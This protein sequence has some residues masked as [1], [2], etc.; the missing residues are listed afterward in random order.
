M[1][2]PESE[3]GERRLGAVMFTDV[4][5]YSSLTSADEARALRLLEDHRTALRPVIG[6][7]HGTEVKT[8]G[9]AF[10][11][12][13]AS[14]VEAVNCAVEM[15]EAMVRLN[16]TR[17]PTDRLQ[18]RVGIHV[19]D[20]VH[21]KGDV[22]GDAVNVA[23]RVEPLAEPGGICITRQ[24]VD[25]VERKVNLKLVKLGTRDL[26]NISHPIEVYKVESGLGDEASGGPSLDPRRIAILPFANLSADPN[27]RYFADGMTEELISTVSSISELSVISRTSIMRYKDTIV[28]IGEIGRELSAG[29]VLEGSIRKAGNRVRVTTQLIDARSD[30]HLWA[31]SYD[32]DVTDIFAIQGDI[33]GQV[34]EALRVKLVS[35]EKAVIEKKATISTEAHTLYLKGRYSWNDRTR[36][37]GL[38]AIAYYQEAVKID[39]TF[40]LAYCGLSDCYAI[41][42]DRGWISHQETREKS[43]GYA[44]KALDL[45]PGLA[46]AHASMGL[47]LHQRWDLTGAEAELKRSIEL[48]PNFATAYHWYW[49]VLNDLGR[50][51]EAYEAEKRALELD[52]YSSIVRQGI[53]V[54]LM[55]LKRY[56][57]ALSHLD[58]L[59]E[60]DPRFVSVYF[61]AAWT[62]YMKGD[63]AGAIDTMSKGL[64]RS[65]EGSPGMEI[66]LAWLHT[67]SGQY[68]LAQKELDQAITRRGEG[69]QYVSPAMVAMV[70][71]GLGKKDEGFQYLDRALE[72]HDGGLSYFRTFPWL[73]EYRDDPRWAEIDRKMGLKV[74]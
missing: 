19:G 42:E 30:R 52:P 21:S 28:P 43:L 55:Y 53:G 4:V 68:E 49:G 11:V 59:A 13:F 18:I 6:R 29:T 46:E 69:G 25:N 57:E 24:V 44:Q 20:I 32:R 3:T 56:D 1:S 63:V 10:L 17:R 39:P 74:D 71:F 31:Q 62:R 66:S 67:K 26:K 16:A 47:V 35:K 38:K 23:A 45:D 22:L 34:A 40:A 15:Q 27:D 65:A 8:I 33:A 9:D 60:S 64:D 41:L 2:A 51:E 48:K 58:G 37:G 70:K 36:E 54:A 72:E 73:A 61:W 14:A 5:G 12:E 50:M 7:H